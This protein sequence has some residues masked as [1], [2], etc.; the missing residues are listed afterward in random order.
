M[1]SANTFVQ[2]WFMQNPQRTTVFLSGR[3]TPADFFG[4]IWVGQACPPIYVAGLSI[5]QLQQLACAQSS[6]FAALIYTSKGS[7][8]HLHLKLQTKARQLAQS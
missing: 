3:L 5:R 7:K 1:T 6:L 4:A 8:A 2:Y